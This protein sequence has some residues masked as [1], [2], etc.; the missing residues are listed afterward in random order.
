MRYTY[1]ALHQVVD[2]IT[3]YAGPAGNEV[4]YQTEYLRCQMK[5]FG[6]TQCQKEVLKKWEDDHDGRCHMNWAGCIL[7]AGADSVGAIPKL[8]E[9][10]MDAACRDALAEHYDMGPGDVEYD[11]NGTPIVTFGNFSKGG[12]VLVSD[13]VERI[14][15]D[16][17]D[18]NGSDALYLLTSLGISYL[19][20]KA[21]PALPVGASAAGKLEAVSNLS[22]VGW[23]WSPGDGTEPPKF[24]SADSRTVLAYKAPPPSSPGEW[25]FKLL[26]GD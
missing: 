20:G 6:A 17:E 24:V 16:Y 22:N 7:Q 5:G 21:I 13:V 14:V 2:T 15:K 26:F 25:F 19:T 1:N 9:C 18:G 4:V 10:L 23:L 3:P 11:E 8:A 12:A